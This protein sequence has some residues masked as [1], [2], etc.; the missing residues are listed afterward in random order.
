MTQGIFVGRRIK[1]TLKLVPVIH[2]ESVF[3][4]N[5]HKPFIILHHAGD[6]LLRNAF[7][8][9]YVRKPKIESIAHGF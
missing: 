9:G 5:P 1:I 6:M 8:V 3:G 7:V 2:T 4:S